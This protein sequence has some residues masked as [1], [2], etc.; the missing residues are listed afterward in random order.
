MSVSLKRCLYRMAK[1][2]LSVAFN[3]NPLI[4]PVVNPNVPVSRMLFVPRLTIGWK[5]MHDVV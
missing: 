5:R 4:L 2:A 3:K 1:T